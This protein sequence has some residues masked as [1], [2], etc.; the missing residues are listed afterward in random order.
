MKLLTSLL[1]AA[2]WLASHAETRESFDASWKFAR[3]DVMPDGSR[4]AEPGSPA[5]TASASSSESSNPPEHA[6][7]GN[8]NTRW[9]AADGSS[10]QSLTLDLGRSAKL[11]GVEID[12]EK[13]AVYPCKIDASIDGSKW[14]PVEDRNSATQASGKVKLST[15]VITRYLRVTVGSTPP[16]QWASIS[17]LRAL[18]ANGN[19]LK[20]VAPAATTNTSPSA[21]DF[22]DSQW[23]KINLPHDWAIEGPFRIDLENETGKLPWP[24]IGWY[25]KVL[26][27][28]TADQG[29][30]IFLDFDGAMSQSKI[31]V[32]G[33]AAGEWPYGYASF[34]VDITRFVK[35]GA[36]NAIAVRLDNP[37]RSSRWY[38]GGGIYRH[39]WL[40]KS[41]PI[42]FAHHGVF[43]TSENITANSADVVVNTE[44]QGADRPAEL[45]VVH[46]L[47]DASGKRVASTSSPASTLTARMQVKSPTLW[48]TKNPYLYTLRST[49]AKGSEKID[50]RDTLI[51]IRKAEWKPDGFYLNDQRIQIKGVCNHH[52]LGPIGAAFNERAAE[53]QIELLKEMGCNSIRTSHNPPAPQLLDLCDRMGMLVLDELFDAWSVAKKPNDYHIHFDAWHERDVANFIRRDRNHP[54]VIAWSTGNEIPEQGDPGKH[55]ISTDLSNLMRKHDPSRKIT[56]GCNDL[57]AAY[58]GFAETID[59]FGLNYPVR[60]PNLPAE[61]HSKKP[62]LPIINTET[63]S[64]VSS[65]GSYYFPATWDKGGGSFEFQVSSYELYAPGWANRPDLDFELLD[66]NPFIAGEYVWTGFDYIGEPTPYN[67]DSTYALNFQ[68]PEER[69]KA[70]E[71]LKKI[72]NRPPS[73]SSYFGILDLCGFPKDRYYLYQAHW[74]PDF[75]MA[76]ILPH[77]NWQERIG[78]ITPVHVFTSGDEAELFLNGKSLG[79]KK[80]EPFTY[81]IVWEKVKY[82]PGE[83]KVVTWKK[84]K[85]WAKAERSTTGQA[86]QL[87]AT[88]DRP[89][90]R[91]DGNDLAYITVTIADAKAR[92]VPRSM[93]RLHFK[94][95]GPAEIVA[96]CNGDATNHESLQGTTMPA[97]NGLCQVIVRGK[98]GSPGTAT[99]SVASGKLPAA[100]VTL[101][102]R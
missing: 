91:A 77:W 43:A 98:P 62:Q 48:D 13:P 64:C 101:T 102:T 4:L 34:R 5:K 95:A 2:S 88:A 65:R 39:V 94:I 75:P 32:N 53:R 17:E 30:A 82:Q 89:E 78:Q 26:N 20:P 29:K 14:Q 80:K 58:N 55:S 44:L 67:Q 35:W 47:L 27:L 45:K 19:P 22:D 56:N 83:L 16:T 15:S 40:V 86:T 8:P 51:G 70:L 57:G 37:A 68:N 7:D 96:V 28:T 63:S 18:D 46:E 50:S 1:L 61:L 97:F 73:R 72:G 33:Q 23:R 81:R 93:D 10:N 84:G 71:D 52:D 69:K 41:P 36:P 38:P 92:L 24:G 87:L 66:R 74:R 12:W 59:I 49:L 42:H 31:F 3:F 11:G 85:E 79:R 100:K 54:S 90:I 99:L 60:Q 76:H 9:C 6:V 21:A 25:R